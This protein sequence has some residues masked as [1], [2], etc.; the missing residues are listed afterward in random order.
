VAVPPFAVGP[1]AR[2]GDT[3]VYVCALTIFTVASALCAAAQSPQALIF[4]RVIQGFGGGMILPC[5]STITTKKAGPQRRGRVAG[6]LGVPL[7][8]APVFGPILGGWLVDA[9][10]W[11]AIFLLNVPIGVVALLLAQLVLEPGDPQPAHRLDWLGLALASPGLALLIFGFSE[12]PA[13]GFESPQT[14]LPVL[15]GVALV[16]T[17]FAH[18]WRSEEPLI[19]VKTF[20]YSRAGMAATTLL[21]LSGSAFAAML[22]MPV[23]FQLARG[24]S[25]LES[26]LLLLP[27]GIG[28]MIGLPLAGWLTDRHGP[29][30][31]PL[32]SLPPMIVGIVPFTLL[33][34]STPL[35][36]LCGFNL[37]V[38]FGLGFSFMPTGT[39][40][41]QAVPERAIGRTMTA[42]TAIDLAGGSIGAALISVVLA[43][44]VGS[45]VPGGGVQ[46]TDHLATARR[47]AL[48][49]PLA[50][51]FASTFMWVLVALVVAIGPA[52]ALAV[53]WGAARRAPAAELQSSP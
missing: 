48:S 15:L 19:D 52:L 31:V 50:E 51:A 22:L 33:T 34:G 38:G 26:A 18:S 11:R 40:A 1:G 3:R 16:A 24:T 53:G 49:G 23:Y 9:V 14:W 43:S 20:V 46:L 17:F 41:V 44:A 2:F 32:V 28:T 35:S 13:H 37:L 39:A 29:F 5:V 47:V 36:L 21:F 7:L 25:A 4:F 10:S 8:I 12:S 6:I 27:Q 45:A 30:W 42:M